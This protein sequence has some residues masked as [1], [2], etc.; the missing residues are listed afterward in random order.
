VKPSKKR[1][2]IP[3]KPGPKEKTYTSISQE[4]IDLVAVLAAQHDMLA[5]HPPV[6][7]VKYGPH[8]I[9]NGKRCRIY[10]LRQIFEPGNKN[11]AYL[12]G[13]VPR[14]SLLVTDHHL[15]ICDVKGTATE[16]YVMPSIV[17][18]DAL[19]A[20]PRKEKTAVVMHLSHP[21]KPESKFEPF[22]NAW[23]LLA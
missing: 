5:E 15:F 18:N 8:L 6:P 4:L 21:P 2:R 20:N 12:R 23:S 17:V 10:Y 16:T 11:N 9:V 22:R 7:H 1:K 19:F 13:T 3:V 14:E